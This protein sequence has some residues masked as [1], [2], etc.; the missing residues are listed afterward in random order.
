[1]RSVRLSISHLRVVLLRARRFIGDFCF[2]RDSA[3]EHLRLDETGKQS[4]PARP[5][6]PVATAIS[7]TDT[8]RDMP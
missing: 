7:V 8:H 1:M 5:M 2:G 4:V 3:A 6:H